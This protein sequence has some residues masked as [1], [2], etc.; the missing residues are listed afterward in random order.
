M[1]HTLE[2]TMTTNLN[3]VSIESIEQHAQ[4]QQSTQ[5][6]LY[7]LRHLANKYGLYDAADWIEKRM[8][9]ITTMPTDEVIK[10]V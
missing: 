5:R 6:Q 4:S 7:L 8:N 3:E 2:L 9:Y 1:V 10:D